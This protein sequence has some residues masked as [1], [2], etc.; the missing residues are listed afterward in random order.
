VNEYAPRGAAAAGAAA[1]AGGKGGKRKAAEAAA[2]APASRAR[3]LKAFAGAAPK[4]RAN[5]AKLPDDAATEALLDDILGGLDGGSPFAGAGAGAGATPAT[6]PRAAPA[7][8]PRTFARAAPRAPLSTPRAAPAAPMAGATPKSVRFA[9]AGAPRAA[10]VHRLAA[11]SRAAPAP[12][13]SPAAPPEPAPAEEDADMGYDDAP[14]DPGPDD[15]DFEEPAAAPAAAA[16]AAPAAAPAEPAAGWASLCDDEDGGEGTPAAPAPAWRDDGSLPLDADQALPFYLLDAVEEPAAPGAVFLFGR[17]PAG[18]P[19]QTVSCCAVVRGVP[20]CLFFVPREP[21]GTP[22]MSALRAAAEG[23]DAEARRALVPA[24]HAALAGVKAEV[25]A[26]LAARGATQMTMKPVLREYAFENR[27]VPRGRQWVLKVR[28]PGGGAPPLPAGLAGE[29]FCAAFGGAQAALEA[30]ML[31]RKVMGPGWLALRRP[32][33]AAPAAQ[34]SWCR[35]EVEVEG[36]KAVAPAPGGRPAPTL[37]VAAVHLKTVVNPATA[38]NEVAAASVVYLPRVDTEGPAAFAPR[39]LR[40]FSAVCRLEGAP[41]PPG[42]DAEVARANASAAGRRSGGAALAAQPNERALLTWLVVRLR[43]VDA[44]VFVGHNFAG[45][46]LGVLLARLQALKVPHW[47]SL[48][49]LRRAKFPPLG[50][51]GHAFG[52]G[53]APGALA[54]VA[55]RLICDTYLAARDLVKEVDYTLGTLSRSLLGEARAELGPGEVAARFASAPALLALVRHTESD[56]WLSLKLAAYLA[57]LPLSRQLAELSG[58]LWARALLGQRAQ[59]IEMLLLHEFHG[60]K[61][62]LP[63]KLTGKERDRLARLEAEAGA[64]A[65]GA[66]AAGAAAA[67]AAAGGKAKG[68]QF[69]GG[70]VLEPKKGLYDRFVLLLDFNS[71]YPSIIQE[72]NICFTT[73]ARPPGGGVPALPAAGGAK[74]PLPHVIGGLVGR[75][76]A[77]KDALR[78]ERDATRRAQLEIRQQALKLLANSMYGCLGFAHSRF[79]A[80]PLAELVTAQGREILQS[81]VDLVQGALGREVIYGDTD[82]IMVAT[83]SEALPEVLALGAAIKREVNKRY[84]LL[85]IEVD[86]VYRAML[87]L[88]KKKYAAVRVDRAADGGAAEVV[89]AKGLD[90]VRRDWSPLAKGAS[91]A[92]LDALLARGAPRETAVAAIHAHLEGLA[93]AVRAGTVPLGKYVVTKQLTKRPE[94]YPDAKSQPHVQVA[95]RRRAA[96]RREGTCAGETVPYVVCEALAEDGATVLAP[97]GKGLAERAFAPDEILASGGR[98]RPDAEYYLAHQVLPVVSRLVAPIEGT[99]AAR[100]AEALGLDGAKYRAAAAAAAAAAGRDDA[101]AAAAAG[102]DDD[103]RFKDCAPL[104]LGAGAFAGVRALL[105]GGP[106]AVDAALALPGAAPAGAVGGAAAAAPGA[107]GARRRLT[108][109]QVANKATLAARAAVADYYAG[110]LRSDDEA[111]PCATRDVCLRAAGEA[112]PGAAPPDLRCSGTMRPEVSE[113][114]LYTQLSHLHRLFDVEGALHALGGAREARGAGEALLAPV[115]AELEAGAA[116]AARLRDRCGYRW[117]DMSSVFGC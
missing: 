61:F 15:D 113:A 25:R 95:L 97:E 116:A 85:E 17:V 26:L 71:L 7:P 58:S 13:P 67:G 104:E 11:G 93:A 36:H 83:G 107:G 16:A 6:A 108:P 18:A 88:K 2:V 74:A 9:P 57:V 19:G 5:A 115:R 33:R 45:F 94:D 20:R 109:A 81:T 91:Q 47:S 86:G 106:A 98:L 84:R 44:D 105:K 99:D 82:S 10:L 3:L 59:R 12:T 14:A 70:L 34:L 32:V 43:E 27:A 1:A 87:L 49:R 101:L 40:H 72:Y 75:R 68:P 37:V 50:G 103:D 31:K 46:D 41:L 22:E 102:L 110:R 63:D 64:A 29:T 76:R 62:L 48:G 89:E 80:R 96:G 52:G 111:L 77:V 4:P 38:A 56:A 54:A 35:L 100:L 55:G 73:V 24:A 90:M 21:V 28:L 30:L 114:E 23:G 42:F 65:G 117:V 112:A 78:G 39:E 51:G 60:R 8:A 92:A 69:A 66:G 79:F 53:A